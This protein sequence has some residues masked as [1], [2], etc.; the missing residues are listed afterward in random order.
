MHRKITKYIVVVAC[1]MALPMLVMAKHDRS[2]VTSIGNPDVSANIFEVEISRIDGKMPPGDEINVPVEPGRHTI[3]L[4]LELDVKWT[5]KL[6]YAAEV[7]HNLSLEVEEGTT[8]YLGAKVNPNASKE[9]QEAGTYW[10]PT[11]Y[12]TEQRHHH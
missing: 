6:Q 5:A 11:V 1:A 3:T 12:K 7:A 10:Y 4:L 9:E 8:Y 2:Y